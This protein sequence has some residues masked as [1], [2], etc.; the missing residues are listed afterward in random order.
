M[1]YSVAFSP[2]GKQI[3]SGSEDNTVRLWDAA[4]GALLQ[5]LAGHSDPVFSV[6]FSLDGKQVVSGSTDKTVRLWDAATGALEQTLD[7]H[8]DMVN[9]VA[10]SP[11][12]KQIVSGSRD[13]TVRLW[14]TATGALLQTFK[15]RRD[16]VNSVAFSPEGKLLLTLRVIGYWLA[17]GTTSLLWLPTDYRPTCEAVWDRVVILGHSSGRISFLQIEKGSKCIISN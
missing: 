11:N 8:S 12:G 7:G 15:G 1:V 3:V 17:E 16:S 4:T 6:A 2:N 14:D 10:F 5:T 13:N 9:S